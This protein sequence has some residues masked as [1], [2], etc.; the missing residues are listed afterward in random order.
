MS[1]AAT[2]DLGP[3]FYFKPLSRLWEE[4]Q[5]IIKAYNWAAN[6]LKGGFIKAAV[7]FVDLRGF[8]KLGAQYPEKPQASAWAAFRFLGLTEDWARATSEAINHTYLDKVIGD[9]LLLVIPGEEGP[10]M[11]D[12]LVLAHPVLAK[13]FYE[14]KIG[15]H[16]SRVWL[17][18]IGLPAG[19][20]R[21]E[22]LE[23]VTVMGHVV[24]MAC[25]LA[26]AAG[27]S[28]FCVLPD[29]IKA[30]MIPPS[31]G[32]SKD[33]VELKNVATGSVPIIRLKQRF[34]IQIEDVNTEQDVANYVN[35]STRPPDLD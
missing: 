33:A 18:D 26:G 10:A 5:P 17:G 3:A 35:G 16:W 31:M 19:G 29:S 8:S 22:R 30:A 11:T 28:E 27:V 23:C 14:C 21:H 13:P 7:M 15:A 32:P 1:P 6:P 9:A 25:R 24:N 12:A 20:N 34:T 2:P 4:K